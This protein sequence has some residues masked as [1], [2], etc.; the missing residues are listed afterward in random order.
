MDTVEWNHGYQ[1]CPKI[2]QDYF[3]QPLSGENEDKAQE[4][5]A[6]DNDA[7]DRVSDPAWVLIFDG[8]NK[9]E[10]REEV[11]KVAGEHNPDEVERVL[12]QY[13]VYPVADLVVWDVEARLQEL[14][15]SS[16]QLQSMFRISLRPISYT[17]AARRVAANAKLSVLTEDTARRLREI[18]VS[19][20][21]DVRTLDQ[22][23]V[24]L[25]QT[26]AEGGVE[27]S[28]E[29]ANRYAEELEKLQIAVQIMS[30]QEFD[31]WYENFQR[32]EN[33]RLLDQP[34]PN[35]R[36]KVAAATDANGEVLPVVRTTANGED[37]DELLEAAVEE[38]VKRLSVAGLDEYL[39]KRLRNIISTRLR[40]VR[41]SLQ[42]KEVLVRDSK[43]G[44]L[45]RHPEE[46]DAM[47]LV[48]EKAYALHKEE[49]ATAEQRRI[50][51]MKRA[52]DEKREV[53]R[54]EE[55]EAHAD[56]YRQKVQDANP[57]AAAIEAQKAGQ[58]AP[59]QVSWSPAGQQAVASPNVDPSARPPI[60]SIR[61][62]TRLMSLGNELGSITLADF[63]RIAQSPEE[64]MERLW[65]KLETL[66]QESY[67]KLQEG[68]QA[69]RQSP[70][71]QQYLQ[72]VAQSFTSGRPVAEIASELHEK[73]PNQPTPQEIGAILLLNNR[74]NV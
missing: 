68:A 65:Q 28:E 1:H 15:V 33:I 57:W 13:I 62:P 12:L 43:V 50:E 6:L 72:L 5:L 55:S 7:W 59:G 71:Q 38:T 3:L 47:V 21:K 74:L 51:S 36:P 67:E 27:F 22:V 52:Q 45:D 26:Q 42:V 14:G 8:M 2:V 73:D 49:L 56:W 53:R 58:P 4:L 54:K 16:S 31:T 69:W 17:V 41:N 40:D 46:A 35:Q 18:L 34:G 25:Q 20:M 61:P 9:Q 63:R 39:L 37:Y 66:K 44:G 30:E 70:L 48:I 32:E 11:K 19:Y 24:A 64:A 29:Q 23:K 10:F 60:D